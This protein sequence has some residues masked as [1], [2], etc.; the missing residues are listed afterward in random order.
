[1]VGEKDAR[2]YS[3]CKIERLKSDFCTKSAKIA[4]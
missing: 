2:F 4:L 3:M 1:M